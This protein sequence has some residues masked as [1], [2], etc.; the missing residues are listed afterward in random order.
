LSKLKTFP[1]SEVDLYETKNLIYNK[2][3]AH[4]KTNVRPENRC[5]FVPLWPLLSPFFQ[6]IF[7]VEQ[8]SVISWIRFWII[9]LWNFVVPLPSIYVYLQHS[10][11]GISRL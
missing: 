9:Y 7:P 3:D 2:H 10:P 5:L 1:I 8:F 4:D 6:S 11:K